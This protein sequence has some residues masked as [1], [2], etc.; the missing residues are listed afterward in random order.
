[1]HDD[2]NTQYF[3][4]IQMGSPMQELNMLFDTGSAETWVYS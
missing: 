2:N 4:K 1:M 3:G